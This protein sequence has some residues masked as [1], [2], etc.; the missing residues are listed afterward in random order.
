MI[1][2]Y[3]CNVSLYVIYTFLLKD[4]ALFMHLDAIP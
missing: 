4:N 3:I 1:N 2:K